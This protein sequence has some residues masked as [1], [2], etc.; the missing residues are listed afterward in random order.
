MRDILELQKQKWKS[1]NYFNGIIWKKKFKII[2]V[3]VIFVKS[4]NQR[5]LRVTIGKQL[6]LPFEN[7]AFDSLEYVVILVTWFIWLLFQID[8]IKTVV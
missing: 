5:K 4:F 2:G 7:I 3:D 8:G 1:T 6:K